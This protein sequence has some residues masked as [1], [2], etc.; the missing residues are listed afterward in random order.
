MVEGGWADS[1]AEASRRH[2][3]ARRLLLVRLSREETLSRQS[4]LMILEALARAP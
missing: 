3:E 2:P 4:V 1:L